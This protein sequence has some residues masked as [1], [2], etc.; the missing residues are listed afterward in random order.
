MGG[1]DC[2]CRSIHIEMFGEVKTKLQR[3]NYALQRT[4]RALAAGLITALCGLVFVLT[5]AGITFERTF[6]LD[7]LFKMRGATPPGPDVTV[8]GINSR[9]GR[10]LNLAR[11]PHDWPRTVHARAIQRLAKQNASAIVFD[12]DFSRTKSAA[13]D[14]AFARAIAEANRVIL[15]EWLSARREPLVSASGRDIGWTWIEQ[16]QPPSQLLAQAARGLGPFPLPKVDQAAFEF[17]AFKPSAG[18]AATTPAIALQFKALEFYDGWL[19]VLRE[20]K[21]AGTESLPVNASEVKQASDMERL[22][23]KLRRMF[24]DD[25]SLEQRVERAIERIYSETKM[26]RPANCSPPS[27][28]STLVRT[29]TT[30]TSTVRPGRSKHCPMSRC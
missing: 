11:F 9:T 25:A 12:I 17:W 27:P 3:S 22:M 15:F 24:R 7:W 8:V 19:S 23:Q 10:A 26:G 20:A 21:A 28:P 6:G 14:A 16:K 29:T 13:E 30:S 2:Q 5:P 1:S 18:D 4:V